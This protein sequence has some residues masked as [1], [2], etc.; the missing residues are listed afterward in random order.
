MPSEQSAPRKNFPSVWDQALPLAIVA[1]FLILALLPL[2]WGIPSTESTGPA[3]LLLA[4]LPAALLLPFCRGMRRL[5]A[6]HWFFALLS[7][8][9]FVLGMDAT[10]GFEARRS[11]L[12]WAAAA[13]A[14]ALGSALSKRARFQVLYGLAW[15][16]LALCTNIFWRWLQ[17]PAPTWREALAAP[18]GNRSD[19]LEFA[20][21]GMVFALGA[22]L[23]HKSRLFSLLTLGGALG[24][25]L[26]MGASPVFSGI[27]A[28]LGSAAVTLL[29]GS[30]VA[31]SARMG[32][33]L[34]VTGAAAVL[35]F[36]AR[37]LLSEE[38]SPSVEPA[39]TEAQANGPS[40]LGSESSSELDKDREHGLS[41]RLD[42]W[43]GTWNMI[44][45]NPV[46]GVGPGQFTQAFPPYR[47][48]RE[49]ERS[50]HGGRIQNPV[51]VEHAHSDSLI[52]LAE[53]GL[54]LGL[55][56][57]ALLL[58]I[59]VRAIVALRSGDTSLTAP[60]AAFLGML[61]WGIW[62]APLMGPVYSHGL[63]WL[64][65]GMVVG[66]TPS[67]QSGPL[68]GL[69][70]GP[71]E[72]ALGRTLAAVLTFAVFAQSLTAWNFA[73]HGRSLAQA[74]N[75]HN[76][77][78]AK[79]RSQALSKALHR[80][81]DSPLAM[82][83]ALHGIPSLPLAGAD[84]EKSR[85]LLDQLIRVRP[86]HRGIL[87]VLGVRRARTGDWEQSAKAFARALE[88]Y[89]AY[90]RALSNQVRMNEDRGDLP[91]L[92]AALDAASEHGA[93]TPERWLPKAQQ[94]LAEGLPELAAVYGMR[95]NRD[96]DF[97]DAN[98][99]YQQYRAAEAAGEPR[100]S[101]IYH[102][103]AQQLFARDH[104]KATDWG[105]AL[106]SYRQAQ[107]LAADIAGGQV[108]LS[109][110]LEMAAV[111]GL[112]GAIEAGREDLDGMRW[113]D[114]PPRNRSNLPDWASQALESM[115]DR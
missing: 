90:G 95:H 45:A 111:R 11:A 14:F 60:A 64:C 63:A 91:A 59:G 76:G 61:F 39:G 28:L 53:W 3:Y 65:A 115:L 32:R 69:M 106:R 86:N 17:D 74:T 40:A 97:S 27:F 49:I 48:A 54:P 85:R 51:E 99:C 105:S 100:P 67:K 50:S 10:D 30:G 82:E 110:R 15:L 94:L 35:A 16:P 78:S 38:G 4:L 23:L 109:L 56:I 107:R 29:T 33:L 26:I 79:K 81:P 42:I 104:A 58:W 66:R 34:L 62:N 114:I 13:L 41:V 70:T 84:A 88:I 98:I 12:V 21:P 31:S 52:A 20:W 8:L 71:P 87:N 47:L 6:M 25:G 24:C 112:D 75:P 103:G 55:L 36:G 73:I 1:G 72:G 102:I 68:A 92:R 9:A 101:K 57:I 96:L 19:M 113:Q 7:L 80:E 77:N 2:L 37:N 93:Y 44:L 89:P 46:K 83:L 108:P 43:R 18:L 5:G 22:F